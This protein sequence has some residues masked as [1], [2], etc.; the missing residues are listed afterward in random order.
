MQYPSRTGPIFI[1]APTAPW[2]PEQIGWHTDLRPRLPLGP[3]LPLQTLDFTSIVTPWSPEQMGWHPDKP[4]LFLA[5][6]IPLPIYE[7]TPIVAPFSPEMVV[8]WHPDLRPRVMLGPR[9]PLQTLDFTSIVTPWSVE[10]TGWHPDRPRLFQAPR[11]PLPISEHTPVIAPFSP[12]MVAGWHPDQ[13]PRLPKHPRF[14]WSWAEHTP[15]GAIVITVRNF[16]G[17]TSTQT[18]TSTP[19]LYVIGPPQFTIAVAVS[20]SSVLYP[21]PHLGL[22]IREQEPGTSADGNTWFR[23]EEDQPMIGV[24][25]TSYRPGVF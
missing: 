19:A 4:K 18:L 15:I 5:P 3:R 16:Q 25:P 14:G 17:Y 21:G 24:S 20:A 11:I 1:D 12:E 22:Y 13:A 6:R 23:W 9:L 2:G 7:H 8:G 10:Q